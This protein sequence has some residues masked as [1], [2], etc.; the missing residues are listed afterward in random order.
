M[1]GVEK[2]KEV[3]HEFKGVLNPIRDNKFIVFK[4]TEFLETFPNWELS[5]LPQPLKDAVVIRTQDTFAGPAL[6]G[7]A[8][9]IAIAE[10]I[11]REHDLPVQAA[12]L[13]KIADYFSERATEADEG[14]RKLPD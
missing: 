12:R 4:R 9:A 7:Y 3:L 6:H 11:L 5:D 2:E 8:A 13:S 10:Q 14:P 1:N